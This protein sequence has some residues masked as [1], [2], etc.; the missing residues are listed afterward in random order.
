MK[1][2]KLSEEMSSLNVTYQN[3]KLQ[4]KEF[5]SKCFK[6]IFMD[7]MTTAVKKI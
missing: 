2:L 6:N 3:Q 1:L 7:S 4:I 5:F